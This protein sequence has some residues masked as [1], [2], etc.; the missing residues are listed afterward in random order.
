MASFIDGVSPTPAFIMRLNVIDYAGGIDAEKALPVAG[1]T[2][3]GVDVDSTALGLTAFWRPEW[4][5]IGE[6]W[7]FAMSA[8]VPFVD[9]TV[10]AGVDPL[11]IG[12]TVRRSDSESGIGDIVLMPVMLNYTINDEWS[13]NFRL[14]IY[15]PTGDYEVG[16]LANPGKNFW[17]FEPVAALMYFGKKNGIEASIFAAL[18]FNQENPDTNY[19]SGTQAHIE[20]TFAQHFPLWGGIAGAGATGYWYQQISDDS[21]EGASFGGFRARARGIGPVVSW[22]KPLGEQEFVAELKWL[23]EFN[24]EK[25][26]E[27]DIVFLKVMYR[28]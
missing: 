24:V 15:A 27:G 18:D 4:G 22:I 2:A 5:S 3:L 25:R 7:S 21:G 10:A 9:L 17:T 28:F 14:G 20:A 6:R 26:P 16:R 1:L 8:T 23:N 13:T 11:D 19:K 12:V